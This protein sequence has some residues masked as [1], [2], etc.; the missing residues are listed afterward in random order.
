M[1]TVIVPTM[2]EAGNISP[3]I[4]R[5]TAALAGEAAEILFVDDSH[6]DTPQIIEALAATS[7]LPLRLLHRPLAHRDGLSGAVVLG[8]Q[9]AT[10]RWVT[11]MDGDLQHP[12]ELVP[13]MLATAR[14]LDADVVVA[15]RRAT[16]LG[17]RGLTFFRT[18]TS[19]SL[20]ILARALFPRSL[21]DVSD[22]L[23]GFFLVRR[24]QVDIARLRPSGFKILLEI[25]VRC[26]DRRIAE[27]HFDFAE[28]H[29]GESKAD[30]REGI[31]YF[32]HLL[33]LRLTA[34]QRPMGKYVAV[35]LL[36]FLLN[37]VLVWLMAVNLNWIPFLAV[38]LATEITDLLSFVANRRFVFPAESG[39]RKFGRYLFVSQL[40]LLLR[41]PL[42]ALFFNFFGWGI[43]VS[44]ILA[45][46]I[47]TA[48]R[49]LLSD[50]WI[51]TRD[52]L[53]HQRKLTFYNLH[54]L[55]TIESPIVL[56][57]LVAFQVASP[58]E[59]IDLRLRLDRHGTPRRTR[60]TI[61]FDDGL[62]RLGFGVTVYPFDGYAE[63]VAS[64]L[65]QRSPAVLFSNIIEPLIRWLLLER[66]ALLV[67]AGGVVEET[68][69]V[70]IISH[71]ERPVI[72]QRVY[73]Y[74]AAVSGRQ[75]LSPAQLIVSEGGE[76]Y[77][78]TK[79]LKVRQALNR[80]WMRRLGARL[81]GWGLPVATIYT[82]GQWLWPPQVTGEPPAAP[83][84]GWITRIDAGSEIDFD[85]MADTILENSRD[86]YGFP[87]LTLLA[88]RAGVDFH[89]IEREILESAI[90]R[91]K[92]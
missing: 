23:T 77:S 29:D 83:A 85:G 54:D 17:P 56:P 19:Q 92:N 34:H 47:T 70:T 28:R 52:L 11:V 76:V 32:R 46:A 67:Q 4:S 90:S 8:L 25:L 33:T 16:V 51:W 22:P 87:L 80:P 57:D 35:G 7:A 74:A 61:A 45:I 91:L 42:F 65:V 40:F 6:D 10:G 62:G 79:P 78:F 43:L 75:V 48:V 5:L 1:L 20:T 31:R 36:S 69:G 9:E 15:S 88:E 41:L 82:L 30:F 38:G 86:P 26:P 12:P 39:G 58:P 68:G 84:P 81:R 24:D 3:L 49:Y 13:D 37:N 50:R 18:I 55:L 63:V 21:K 2:N 27:L 53:A 66:R 73:K 59:K 71:P 64:P 72:V 89:Q 44:N 14:R 60:D